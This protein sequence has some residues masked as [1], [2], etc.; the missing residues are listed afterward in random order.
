MSIGMQKINFIPP[1]FFDILQRYYKRA[2][3]GTLGMPDY[4]QQKRYYQPEKKFDVYVHA[5]N[6]IYPSPLS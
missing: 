4:D 1:F 6:H 5:K 3:L 2:I